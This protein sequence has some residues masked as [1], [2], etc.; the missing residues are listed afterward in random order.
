MGINL[1]GCTTS[2]KSEVY[3]FKMALFDNG[4]SEEF[5]LF[6]RNFKTTID[7]S[8]TLTVNAELQYLRPLLR[9]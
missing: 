9:G 7:A 3:K 2:E 4:E 1:Y 6:L 5:L 8:G